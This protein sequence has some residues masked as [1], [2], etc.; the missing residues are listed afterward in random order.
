MIRGNY[1]W[2]LMVLRYLDSALG[3]DGLGTLCLLIHERVVP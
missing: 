1:L 3:V 2:A